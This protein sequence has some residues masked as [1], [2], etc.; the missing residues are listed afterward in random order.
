[1]SQEKLPQGELLRQVK[2]VFGEDLSVPSQQA[3][4]MKPE[5]ELLQEVKAIFGDD[6]PV[7]QKQT[8][9]EKLMS[10]FSRDY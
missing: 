5:G 3:V 10:F 2:A 6:W 9:R 8:F 1:M 7:D 4:Q